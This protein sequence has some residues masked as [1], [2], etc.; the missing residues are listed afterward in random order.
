MCRYSWSS[1]DAGLW[2]LTETLA[3][4]LRQQKMALRRFEYVMHRIVP[5]SVAVR[6]YVLLYPQCSLTMVDLAE[7]VNQAHKLEKQYGNQDRR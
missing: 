2:D 7:R 1:Q 6:L 3:A 5:A 4:V